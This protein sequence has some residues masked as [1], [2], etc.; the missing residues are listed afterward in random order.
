M[1]KPKN[2]KT[3]KMQQCEHGQIT[4]MWKWSNPKILKKNGQN[5]KMWKQLKF[6]NVKTQKCEHVQIAKNMKTVKVQKWEGGQNENL[7]EKSKR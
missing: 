4:K 1:W 3:V 7:W 2:V 6:K 5:A